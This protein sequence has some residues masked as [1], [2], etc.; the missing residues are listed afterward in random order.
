MLHILHTLILFL[1]LV[2]SIHFCTQTNVQ[3]NQLWLFGVPEFF[4]CKMRNKLNTILLQKNH[5][6]I[7]IIYNLLYSIPC[8][9]E[10]A[11]RKERAV[12]VRK[13]CIRCYIKAVQEGKE[14]RERRKVKKLCFAQ[15][16]KEPFLCLTCFILYLT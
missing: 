12:N 7:L 3:A 15:G 8:Q 2:Q 4:F 13:H 16:I 11:K 5:I 14:S 10:L 1:F 6:I 9:H